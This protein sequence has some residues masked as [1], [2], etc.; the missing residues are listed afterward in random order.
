MPRTELT[1]SGSRD[2]PSEEDATCLSLF[3]KHHFHFTTH[4]KL[5]MTQKNNKYALL[6]SDLHSVDVKQ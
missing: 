3:L 2:V 5:V 6:L 4:V 1:D